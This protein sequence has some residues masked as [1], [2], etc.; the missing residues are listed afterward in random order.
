MTIFE[1]ASKMKFRFPYKGLIT[2]E[3]L[4]DLSVSQLDVV[5]KT[6]NKDVKQSQEDSLLCDAHVEDIELRTKI[7]IVKHIFN[8]KQMEAEERKVAAAN[9]EKKQR[10]LEILARKQDDSLQNMSEDELHRMLEEIG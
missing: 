9:A 5:Y 2:T 3:D 10:I 1:I 6:L 8:V 7:E 4:W